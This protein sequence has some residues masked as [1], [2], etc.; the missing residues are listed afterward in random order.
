MPSLIPHSPTTP[1]IPALWRRA[2]L[3]SQPTGH[4]PITDPQPIRTRVVIGQAIRLITCW[5]LPIPP[6]MT[7][8]CAP[9]SPLSSPAPELCQNEKVN[10]SRQPQTAGNLPLSALCPNPNL[11]ASLLHR[12]SPNVLP[13]ATAPPPP[14]SP[15]MTKAKGKHLPRKIE[16]TGTRGARKGEPTVLAGSSRSRLP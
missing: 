4:R 13:S 1:G 11:Y 14:P 9:A 2:P 16:V 10:P 12:P 3:T 5:P 7:P 15:A 8:H 6:T